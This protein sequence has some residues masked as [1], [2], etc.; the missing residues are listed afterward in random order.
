MAVERRGW[1]IAVDLGQLVRREEPFFQRKAAAF[2]DGTSRMRREAQV[3]TCEGLGVILPGL[4]GIDLDAEVTNGALDLQRAER[5]SW[6]R[7]GG[8]SALS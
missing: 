3:R 7:S 5:L 6:P 8:S 1:V 4:L 2:R